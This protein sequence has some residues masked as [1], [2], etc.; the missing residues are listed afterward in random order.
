MRHLSLEDLARL[1]DEPQGPGEAAHLRDC[2]ACRLELAEMRAQGAELADLPAAEPPPELWSRIEARL[3]D[4]GLV[5]AGEALPRHA[6]VR[7]AAWWTPSLRA[8][9]AVLLVLGGAALGWAFRGRTAAHGGTDPVAVGP[10]RVTP[11]AGEQGGTGLP[12]ASAVPG[13][14]LAST[15]G[16]P[17][18]GARSPEAVRAEQALRRAEADY[19]AALRRYAEL[20]D[21]G[22]GADV[23]TR[24]RALD[25]IVAT[26]RQA[27]DRNPG[28]PVANG[29]HLA[30]VEERRALLHQ[31][32]TQND[33]TWY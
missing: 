8:A 16:R 12:D 22:S 19:A 10:I 32:A 26:T 18:A 33:T 2:L 24:L 27:I 15:G 20:A 30:A 1:V 17:A 3:L 4:E 28:D 6:A 5:C 25:G 31:V 11:P 29:Y 14:A 7:R 21:P 23:G 9:A 13:A